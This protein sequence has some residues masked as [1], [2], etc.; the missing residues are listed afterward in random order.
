MS[1]STLTEEE[2]EELISQKKAKLGVIFFVIYSFFYAGFVLI[3]VFNYELLSLQVM[4]GVNLAVMYGIALIVFAVLLGVLYNYFCSKY[5][6][7][8]STYATDREEVQ[9]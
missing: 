8:A 7:S 3:G 6:N 5:E 2:I 4:E 1:L 9:K